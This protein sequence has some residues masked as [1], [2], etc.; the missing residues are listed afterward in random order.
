MKIKIRIKDQYKNRQK[1][2]KYKNREEHIRRMNFGENI[3]YF[4][5]SGNRKE[6]EIKCMK[7]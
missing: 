2:G 4:I 6:N 1:I 7:Q 5:Q 3:E